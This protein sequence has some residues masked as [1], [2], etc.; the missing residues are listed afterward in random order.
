MTHGLS[1]KTL[2]QVRALDAGVAFA[3]VRDRTRI[4]I[5]GGDRVAFLH[6]F[7]TNDIKSL[8]VGGGCEAFVTN[9]KGKVLGHV[10]VFCGQQTLALDGTRKQTERIVAHL[11]RY[12]IREDVELRDIGPET[13]EWLVGGSAATALL[14]R[15]VDREIPAP[16]LSHSECHLDGVRVGIRR[17]PL[18]VE[19][20][21]LIV[22]S[23]ADIS[24]IGTALA[25]AGAVACEAEALEI[26]RIEAGFPRYGRD[27]SEDNLPQE[28]NRDAQAINFTKGCYL[29]QETVAR[30]DA[31]G[32]VNRMLCGL[33]WERSEVPAAGESLIVDER[34][35]GQITSA[36]WSP[37]VEAPLTL[38][39]VR[40]EFA[41]IG[42]RIATNLGEAEVVAL[43]V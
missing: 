7:C 27:I 42:S 35:V 9:L 18:L 36:A 30:I 26:G 14:A 32:H 12:I 5:A 28:V 15:L 39:Y 29:G 33:R 20:A 41:R 8:A 17:V 19:P 25:D 38:A 3:D 24:Q 31:L 16:L 4:E 37:R 43:P 2:E 13:G 10:F 40:R 23:K 21:F 22:C 11:D 6:G 1:A 34:V